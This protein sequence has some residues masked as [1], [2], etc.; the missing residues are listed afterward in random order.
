MCVVNSISSKIIKRSALNCHNTYITKPF[1]HTNA[2]ITRNSSKCNLFEAYETKDEDLY[3]NFCGSRNAQDWFINSDL[4]LKN[5][6]PDY[7]YKFHNGFMK[8]VNRIE[9]S[10][11]YLR[12]KDRILYNNN[13]I[14]TGH[15]KGAA[16]ASLM[17]LRASKIFKYSKI[18]LVTF[19]IPN[20]ASIEFF[21]QLEDNDVEQNHYIFEDDFL[22][23]K[24][25][26]DFS[27]N[28]K[29]FLYPYDNTRNIFQK[30]NMK[31]YLKNL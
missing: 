23:K 25:I 14:F 29:T 19:A 1:P 16:I 9:E 15:S 2:Y 30:H 22:C 26:G 4:I 21:E 7:K 3:I 10:D 5:D 20:I 24:G 8:S 11:E 12:V 28:Y 27:Y 6:S 13:I 18:K 17:A 31:R